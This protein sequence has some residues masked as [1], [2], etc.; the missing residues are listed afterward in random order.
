MANSETVIQRPLV[1]PALKTDAVVVQ[2]VLLLSAAFVL[3]AL[4][5]LTGLPVRWLLPMH[6]PVVLAG[7]CYG[8]RSGLLIG[9]AAPLVSFGVSGMPPAAVLPAMTLELAAYGFIAG[10]ARQSFG[11]STRISALASLVGGRVV[12]LAAALMIGWIST[13]FGSYLAAAMAPGLPA[14]LLQLLLLPMIANKWV[15]SRSAKLS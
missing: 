6:W 1:L 4:A 11:L 14:A 2:A 12:F 3:P 15:S 7:L 8:W 10:F 13:S 5:H 9:V